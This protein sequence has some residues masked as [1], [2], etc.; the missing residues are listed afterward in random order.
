MAR[1][2]LHNGADG[3]TGIL[4]TR[5]RDKLGAEEMSTFRAPEMSVSSERNGRRGGHHGRSRA[6]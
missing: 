2:Q 5:V 4:A 3:Q 1:K 6:R